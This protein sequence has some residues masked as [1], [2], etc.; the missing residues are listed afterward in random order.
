MVLAS[1]GTPLI[2]TKLIPTKLTGDAICSIAAPFLI[3]DRLHIYISDYKCCHFTTYR[4][5]LI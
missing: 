3:G 1:I 2:G 5:P 4:R